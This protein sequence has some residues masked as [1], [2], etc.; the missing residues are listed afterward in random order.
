MKLS[1]AIIRLFP[2]SKVV[3]TSGGY[4]FIDLALRLQPAYDVDCDD[5]SFEKL[6]EWV[7]MFVARSAE[8]QML[9]DR[10][11]K[12]PTNYEALLAA[13][14][15]VI[16]LEPV[17]QENFS[18]L[19]KKTLADVGR[20]SFPD[21]TRQLKEYVLLNKGVQNLIAQNRRSASESKHEEERKVDAGDCVHRPAAVPEEVQADSIPGGADVPGGNPGQA[22]NVGG[23]RGYRYL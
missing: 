15:R 23:Y 2:G 11:L 16:S 19:I 6:R 12:G 21:I 8:M 13:D 14:G 10:A 5:I 22:E 17:Q 9:H 3:I 1:E 18:D 20:A 7:M 4:S